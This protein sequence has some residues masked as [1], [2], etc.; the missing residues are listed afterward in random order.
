MLTMLY[1]FCTQTGCTDGEGPQSALVQTTTGEFY[2][3][4]YSGGAH[5]YGGAGGTVFRISAAGALTTLYSFCSQTDCADGE[6]PAAGL[7]QEPNGDMYGTTQAGGANL[8]DCP[9]ACG[10][11]FSLSFGRSSETK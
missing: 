6:W 3:T 8:G 1:S 5:G 10:T 7:L 11:V 4:T 9:N 2:G